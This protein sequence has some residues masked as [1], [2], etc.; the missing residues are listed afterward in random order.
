MF[1]VRTDILPKIKLASMTPVGNTDQWKL[2]K[3]GKVL[4]KKSLMH[5]CSFPNAIGTSIN[6]EHD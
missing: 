5:V 4:P 6:L 2:N 1:P 3:D